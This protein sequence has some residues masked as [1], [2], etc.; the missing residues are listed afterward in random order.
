MPLP[1]DLPQRPDERVLR[2]LMESLIFEGIVPVRQSAADGYFL[3]DWSHDRRPENRPGQGGARVDFRC[4]GKIGVFGRPRL[5]AGSVAMRTCNSGWTVATL[6]AV[7]AGLPG[8]A[9]N[10]ERLLGEMQ[11]T[12]AFCRQNE[13][14]TMVR[15]RR[16]MSLAEMEGALDEGHPYHPCF[17]A[18]TGFSTADH[19][20]YGPES[21]KS[22]QLVWL[23]VARRHVRQALPCHEADFWL[24]ELGPQV[25]DTL[26]RKRDALGLTADDFGL[27]PLHPWQ[28]TNLGPS[29]LLP[30]IDAGEAHFLGALGDCYTATQSIRTLMNASRPMAANVK[31]PMSLV[32]TSSR[33]ILEPHSVCTAPVISAWISGIVA[34]DSLFNTRYPL[35]IL[36]EYAGIIADGEGDLTGQ[37]GAIWRD[38]AQATLGP[39]EAIV[40][41][42]ALMMMEADGRPFADDW[43]LRHG[44]MPWLNRL[45]DIAVLPVWHL[46]VCHGIAVE[47][48]GQNM[49]LVHRDGWPVR[50][51]LRD[52]HESI[53]FSPA[54]LRAPDRMPDFSSLHA[55]YRKAEPDQY[56]WTDNLDSLREL[57]MD[58]L[59]VYNMS[60]ISH[61]L[62]QVYSLPEDRFWQRVEACLAG[63]ATE[64]G[65]GCRQ[66]LLGH[67]SPQ[68]LTES[69]MTRKLFAQQPEYHHRVPNALARDQA[70]L[71]R[72]P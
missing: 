49:L 33:R 2:Q 24:S 48:H 57:V 60:E 52:F 50:L 39:G 69:L 17:K 21:G 13:E 45:I 30:W 5:I 10:R 36:R 65:M 38:S 9:V 25:W 44:L 34:D 68:T 41:F 37:I 61:L 64:N 43:I 15:D 47:A 18:R 58:T 56:Y 51:V 32:N 12:I 28:W 4:R 20:A 11:Q 31:L 8:P 71:R 3:F 72:K 19:Q 63:Y 23:A 35:T 54:F 67:T 26:Q 29:L 55:D 70:E 40:P 6:E 62:E 46:L 22:F 59:F 1:R 27:V 53:E 42:N 66:S 7:V 14:T 16:E